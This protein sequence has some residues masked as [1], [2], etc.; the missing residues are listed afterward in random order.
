ML[1]RS[2][3]WLRVKGQNRLFQVRSRHSRWSARSRRGARWATGRRR[4]SAAK[5]IKPKQRVSRTGRLGRRLGLLGRCSA[6][7]RFRSARANWGRNIVIA[8]EIDGRLLAAL[9]R[10]GLT[11]CGD[12]LGCG[13]FEFCLFLDNRKRNVVIAD[14]QSRGIG[15]PSV[16]H[17]PL[18]FVFGSDEILNLCFRRNMA[19]GQLRLPIFVGSSIAPAQNTLELFI[20]PRVEIH[21]LHTTDMGTHAPMNTGASDANEDSEVPGGPS[22]VLIALAVGTCLV[23]I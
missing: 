10:G 6:G 23:V 2:W 5:E 16:H 21:G 15:H 22:W 14:I 13:T 9:G 12:S 7:G 19:R 17:P 18:G 3:L 8:E 1:D 4:G 20:G 11:R